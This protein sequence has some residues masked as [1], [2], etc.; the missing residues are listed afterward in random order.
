MRGLEERFEQNNNSEMKIYTKIK[1]F[2]FYPLFGRGK[3]EAYL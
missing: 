1:S 2:V 3:G